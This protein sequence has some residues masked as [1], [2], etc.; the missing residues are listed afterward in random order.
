MGYLKAVPIPVAGGYS[1]HMIVYIRALPQFDFAHFLG[2]IFAKY[3]Y[4]VQ[5]HFQQR[6]RRTPHA[7]PV[8]VSDRGA[9]VGAH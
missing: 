3:D 6:L 4:L 2:R 8:I 1:V 7:V 9:V 5:R